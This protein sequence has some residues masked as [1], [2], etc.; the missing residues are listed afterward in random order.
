MLK[1][2]KNW[3]SRKKLI[4]SNHQGKKQPKGEKIFLIMKLST[5]SATKKTSDINEK[6]SDLIK[7]INHEPNL[8]Y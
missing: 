5:I 4:Y 6:N 3:K 7:I 1:N 2:K 8:Y